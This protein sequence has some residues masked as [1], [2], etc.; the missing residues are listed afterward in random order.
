MKPSDLITQAA[1]GIFA[2]R[3]PERVSHYKDAETAF[4]SAPQ[5]LRNR[6]FIVVILEFLDNNYNHV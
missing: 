2:E 4:F 3:H 1:I 5:E 6:I